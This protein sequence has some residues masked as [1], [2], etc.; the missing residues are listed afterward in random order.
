M[1]RSQEAASFVRSHDARTQGVRML[2]SLLRTDQIRCYD[3]TGV[4]VPC[5]GTGQDAD[6]P[7]SGARGPDRFQVEDG[8]VLD[9]LTGALWSQSANAADFPLSW[10]EARAFAANMASAKTHGRAGWQLPTRGLLFSLI[11]H[12]AVNPALPEGHPFTHIFTGYAWT[13]DTCHRFPDQAWHI[14]LGG[15]RVARANKRDSALVWPVCLP[16][17]SPVRDAAPHRF[18]DAGPDAVRDSRTGLVWSRSADPLGRALSWQAALEGIKELNSASRLGARDW[19]MPNVRE[20]ESLV[21][22][23]ADSPALPPG[24]PFRDVRETYWT[25]TTSLYEPRYAWA[26]YFRDG[27]VGVAFKPDTGFFLWPVRG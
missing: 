14:H 27:M 5:A 16:E 25:S 11:S 4:P 13:A 7:A 15:G 12:Q 20:M 6:R 24:H 8:T 10:E 21:D 3:A 2:S 9:T 18:E 1:L 19:R 23:D 26:L 17:G 22:L